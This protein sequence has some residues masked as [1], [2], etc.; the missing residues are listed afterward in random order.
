MTKIAVQ[1]VETTTKMVD[2]TELN[3]TWV[4]LF[5]VFYVLRKGI[6]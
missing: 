5:F 3:G 2:E 4:I 6:G 1:Q